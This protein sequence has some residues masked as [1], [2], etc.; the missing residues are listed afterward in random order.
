MPASSL[1]EEYKKDIFGNFVY[2]FEP[3]KTI[4]NIVFKTQKIFINIFIYYH[5]IKSTT[6]LSTSKSSL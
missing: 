4:L 3:L 6:N 5:Y 2:G 1:S